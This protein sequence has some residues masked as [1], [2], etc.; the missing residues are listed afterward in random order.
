MN[1]VSK[2][3]LGILLIGIISVF[4]TFVIF[5]YNAIIE[6]ADGTDSTSY[7]KSYYTKAIGFGIC[8]IFSGYIL[9]QLI[10][11]LILNL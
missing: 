7:K 8:G 1:V 10:N 5:I 2:D 3:L 11:I 4:V 6:L 9:Y